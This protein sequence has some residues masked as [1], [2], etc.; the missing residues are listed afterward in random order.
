MK[1]A[2]SKLHDIRTELDKQRERYRREQMPIAGEVINPNT[3]TKEQA[4]KL[5]PIIRNYRNEV[6]FNI[7]PQ[8]TSAA[9][10]L[11]RA[12]DELFSYA[13]TELKKRERRLKLVRGVQ[14]SLYI[15]GSIIAIYGSYLQ[16]TRK[17][18]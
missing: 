6:E 2:T 13:H 4:E 17:N 16:A 12:Y 10:E 7:A 8:L 9:N 3:I 15:F 14:I 18:T 11:F 5:R 1:T